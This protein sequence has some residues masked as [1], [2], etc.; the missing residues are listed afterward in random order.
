MR[1][2]EE[3]NFRNRDVISHEDHFFGD[4]EKTDKSKEKVDGV[5]DMTH[6]SSLLK[7]RGG[8]GG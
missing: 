2:K 7:T 6:L 4:V 3:K 1:P 5:I 8:E